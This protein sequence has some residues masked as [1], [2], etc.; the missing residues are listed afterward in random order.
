M[1][2][3]LVTERSIET[4]RRRLRILLA[5]DNGVNRRIA[6]SLLEKMGH[7][8]DLAVNGS[9]AVEKAE[10]E[11]YDLVLMDIQM[12]VMDGLEAT[13]RIRQSPVRG[14]VP[15][16]A[17]TAHALAEERQRCEEAGMN[18]FVTKPFKPLQL[19]S[20]IDEALA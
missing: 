16:V 3:P 5:E 12:P 15:I 14:S 19:C 8:V 10:R 2:R 7:A 4:E 18:G 20:A 13:R 9:E 6:V 11:S 17:L 1:P